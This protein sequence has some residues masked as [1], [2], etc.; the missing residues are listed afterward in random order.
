MGFLLPTAGML[1]IYTNVCTPA[2][3]RK[4][5]NQRFTGAIVV[6]LLTVYTISAIT[7]YFMYRLYIT[8]YLPGSVLIDL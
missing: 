1:T 4:Y 7:F 6:L 3:L 5:I 2:H 8:T